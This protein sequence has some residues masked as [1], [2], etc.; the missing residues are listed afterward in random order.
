MKVLIWSIVVI[1]ALPVTAHASR[2]PFRNPDRDV[3][4]YLAAREDTHAARL[5]PRDAAS[6]VKKSHGGKIL[7]VKATKA[8]NGTAYKVKILT[9]E[10]VVKTVAVDAASGKVSD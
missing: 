9:K 4:I 2:H 8:K 10:G 3:S 7:S 5:S 1:L 6:K